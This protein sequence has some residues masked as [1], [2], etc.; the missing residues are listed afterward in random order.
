MHAALDCRALPTSGQGFLLDVSCAA[1]D[2]VGTCSEV[3]PLSARC[4]MARDVEK[5]LTYRLGSDTDFYVNRDMIN[6]IKFFVTLHLTTPLDVA[7]HYGETFN[8]PPSQA[9]VYGTRADGIWLNDLKS[10]RELG[11]D[12]DEMPESTAASDVGPFLPSAYIPFLLR[13]RE[14]IESDLPRDAKLA[15][16]Q[17]L[18]NQSSTFADI[19]ARASKT[20][21]SF[22]DQFV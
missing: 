5:R 14:I 19:W 4:F 18:K 1:F 16:L 6:G 8:G 17:Q 20:Y 2:D 12:I 7:K 3:E 15:D 10:F 22:P 9:P 13:F 11:I 21:G